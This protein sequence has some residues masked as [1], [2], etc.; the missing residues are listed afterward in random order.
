MTQALNG[1]VA[2]ITGASGGIGSCIAR[3]L[4]QE[5]VNLALMG[6]DMEKLKKTAASL[7]G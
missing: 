4:A 6:R 1:T 2:L 5:G 3:R 7:A